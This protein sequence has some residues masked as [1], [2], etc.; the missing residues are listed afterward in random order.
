MVT[1]STLMRTTSKINQ[2][3]I[4]KKIIFYLKK[5][6]VFLKLKQILLFIQ[7]NKV[8]KSSSLYKFTVKRV[9]DGLKYFFNQKDFQINFEKLTE[10]SSLEDLEINLNFDQKVLINEF[11]TLINSFVDENLSEQSLKR[12]LRIWKELSLT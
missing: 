5:F 9:F 3:S 4:L 11:L 2:F 7:L 1:L 12:S 8:F 6:P 10:K